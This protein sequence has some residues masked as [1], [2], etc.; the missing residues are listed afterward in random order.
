MAGRNYCILLQHL[1]G[2]LNTPKCSL[3]LFLIL[4]LKYTHLS[5][6]YFLCLHTYHLFHSFL[7]DSSLPSLSPTP[8]AAHSRIQF[9]EAIAS[10]L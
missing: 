3:S 8:W 7:S 4:P 6:Y 2:V 1:L 9:C 10:F 5:L